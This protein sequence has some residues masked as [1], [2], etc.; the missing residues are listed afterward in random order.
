MTDSDVPMCVDVHTH[1]APPAAMAEARRGNGID[2]LAIER[3]GGQEWVVHRQGF[4]WP[5][6]RSFYDVEARLTAMDELG[7]DLAVVS[8]APPLFMYWVQDAGAV[9]D[10]CRQ[11]NDA[12]ADFAAASSGRIEAVATLPMQDPD[13]AARELRRAVEE[14]GLKGAEI[15]PRVENT[16]LDELSVRPVLMTA[17]ELGVPLILHPYHVGPRPGLEDFY[18]SNLVG[19][20]LETTVGAARLIFSGVLDELERLNLVL[21]HGGGYLPYQIGRLDHG[22]RVR[23]ESRTCRHTPSSYLTRFWYDTVTHAPVPLE[24]LIRQVGADRVVYGTDFPYD[25]AAGPF[26]DQLAGVA[27]DEAG[28]ARIAGGN[29]LELLG[30]R[31]DHGERSR[32]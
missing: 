4:R 20:P 15:A 24:F 7:V 25:M 30:L 23:A 9:T 13:A 32:P 5:L 1:F 2:G 19:N 26:E 29:A 16:P 27:L 14:L 22:H 21:M 3:A 18:L 6:C 28:L 17:A 10:L 11:T 31:A 12:L 8:M